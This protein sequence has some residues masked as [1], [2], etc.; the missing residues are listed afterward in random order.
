M[1]SHKLAYHKIG[2]RQLFSLDTSQ[3]DYDAML[4]GGPDKN[5]KGRYAEIEE[6]GSDIKFSEKVIF[7][8]SSS[9]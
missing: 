4:A 5:I 3:C 7:Q 6:L 2:I 8:S 1:A 9:Y